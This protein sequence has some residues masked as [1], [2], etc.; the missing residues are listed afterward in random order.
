MGARGAYQ[1]TT[2]ASGPGRLRAAR[3]YVGLVGYM[4]AETKTFTVNLSC[5]FTCAS[6]ARD[7]ARGGALS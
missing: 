7:D 5:K 1:S 6:R 2:A 3:K 4:S